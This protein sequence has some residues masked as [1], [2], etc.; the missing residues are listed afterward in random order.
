MQT[1]N[2]TKRDKWLKR[3]KIQTEKKRDIGILGEAGERL[4]ISIHRVNSRKLL[5]AITGACALWDCSNCPAEEPS[6]VMFISFPVTLQE[7]S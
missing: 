7:L 1:G 4:S 2:R 3:L 5:I 6:Q